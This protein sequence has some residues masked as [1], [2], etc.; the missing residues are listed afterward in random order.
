MDFISASS[1]QRLQ[2]TLVLATLSAGFGSAFQYGYNIAVV[3]TPH[4]VGAGHWGS[5]PLQVR[6]RVA[7]SSW[8]PWGNVF[9]VLKSFYNDTYYARHGTSMDEK[10]MLLLWSCTV[11]M[12]PLGGLLGSLMV[13]G[14]VDK[15][16]R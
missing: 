4:K 2:P 8:L 1:P 14:L 7:R 16:G 13:G 11:S 6:S 12:F 15:C 10:H 3:N 9:Q 5:R